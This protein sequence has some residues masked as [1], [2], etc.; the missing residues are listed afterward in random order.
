MRIQGAARKIKN[1]LSLSQNEYLNI[2][3]TG[4]ELS[5]GKF[6]GSAKKHKPAPTGYISM[7]PINLI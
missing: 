1:K 3:Q 6:Y 2:Y 7:R 5:T 4:I